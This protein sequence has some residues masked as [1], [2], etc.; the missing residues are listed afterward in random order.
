MKKWVILILLTPLSRAITVTIDI[1]TQRIPGNV[2]SRKRIKVNLNSE[3]Y[4]ICLQIDKTLLEVPMYR[5]D[6]YPNGGHKPAIS[7]TCQ[8]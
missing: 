6:I 3:V 1:A 8:L 7:V 5:G 2:R 4:Y